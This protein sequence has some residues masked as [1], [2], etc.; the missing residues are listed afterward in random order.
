M[1]LGTPGSPKY[2]I[3]GDPGPL[4][5]IKMETQGPHFGRSPFS[6]LCKQGATSN[7]QHNIVCKRMG[8]AVYC[9]IVVQN[10]CMQTKVETIQNRGWGVLKS[11]WSTTGTEL[12]EKLGWT[13][14]S[15]RRN[16]LTLKTIHK[17]IHKRGPTYLHEK[18]V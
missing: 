9:G 8:T 13:T 12:R 4:F 7:T 15:H 2:N 5:H 14:L 11:P 3:I 16:L 6:L 17:C 18:F 10:I 1:K